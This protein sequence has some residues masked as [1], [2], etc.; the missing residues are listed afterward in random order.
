MTPQELK[1]SIL[2]LAIQTAL[3]GHL[4][5][6]VLDSVQEFAGAGNTDLLDNL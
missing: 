1:A 6:Q 4:V 5:T 3:E 2:Q